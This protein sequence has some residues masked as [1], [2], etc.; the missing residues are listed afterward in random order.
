MAT[1]RRARCKPGS[2][3]SRCAT[4]GSATARGTAKAGGSASPRPIL[5]PYLR[6]ARSIEELLPWLYLKGIS[7]GDFAEA[8][9]ALPGPDAPG[10]SAS[11]ITRLKAAWAEDHE[12][13][14]RRDLSARRYVCFWADGIYFKPRLDHDKQCLLVIIGAGE[15]GHKDIVAV[16]D[17]YRESEQS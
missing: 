17:G 9:E 6:R 12:R 14:N 2:A 5:P 3:R 15:A 8:L 1:C 16:S 11:T 7:T 10:L 4:P 13:W